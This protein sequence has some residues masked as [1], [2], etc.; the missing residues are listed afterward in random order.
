MPPEER[1]HMPSELD[2]TKNPT[3]KEA[4]EKWQKQLAA[5]VHSPLGRP[6]PQEA[7]MVRAGR[8]I[9][10][11]EKDLERVNKEIRQSYFGIAS[12][13]M[14]ALKEAR[15]GLEMRLAEHYAAIGLYEKAAKLDPRPE[16]KAEYLGVHNAVN[17]PDE[18]REAEQ[19]RLSRIA[20]NATRGLNANDAKAK[21]QAMGLMKPDAENPPR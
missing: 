9:E 14:A 21:L 20:I 15:E 1:W 3:L 4:S 6:S 5:K 7:E 12:R 13:N 11:L 16:Y 18:V 10:H 17:K 19:Y 8:M 2:V